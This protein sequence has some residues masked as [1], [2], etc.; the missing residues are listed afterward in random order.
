M[1]LKDGEVLERVI[2]F[3]YTDFK[4]KFKVNFGKVVGWN[5]IVRNRVGNNTFYDFISFKVWK[6]VL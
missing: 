1:D 3:N 2:S 6:I 4:R 5:L